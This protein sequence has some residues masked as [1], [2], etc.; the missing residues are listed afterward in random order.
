LFAR[1]ELISLRRD[2]R[3]WAAGVCALVLLLAA[4]SSSA[5]MR[6]A[7]EATRA[8]AQQAS[9]R[10]WLTQGTKNPHSA[11]HFG[12]YAFRPLPALAPFE[13]GLHGT[14]G[15]TIYLEAHMANELRDAPDEDGVR[16]VPR[17]HRLAAARVLAGGGGRRR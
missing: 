6:H 4:L 8:E 16:R 11:A 13:P 9:Q 2:R 1:Y 15:T 5:Q 12:V 14:L 10:Q 7:Y 17:A 3:A